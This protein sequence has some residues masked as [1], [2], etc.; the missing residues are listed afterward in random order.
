MGRPALGDGGTLCTPHAP[1]P[2]IPRLPEPYMYKLWR[3]LSCPTKPVAGGE[4]PT[5]PTHPLFVPAKSGRRTPSYCRDPLGEGAPR[6]LPPLGVGLGARDFPEDVFG[7]SDASCPVPPEVDSF[8]VE[9]S[10]SGL[11]GVGPPGVTS[12]SVSSGSSPSDSSS[13]NPDPSDSSWARDG[14]WDGTCPIR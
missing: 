13:L 6:P 14:S 7:R 8:G 4:P 9:A 11:P 3:G 10:G 5:F 12:G 2:S 1:S